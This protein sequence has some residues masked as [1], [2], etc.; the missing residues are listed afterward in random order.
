MRMK[1][2]IAAILFAG[3][4][5]AARA[6]DPGEALYNAKCSVCHQAGGIGAPGQYPP[7]KNRIDKIA[8]SAEGKHYLADLLLYGMV[9]KIQA[10]GA[11]YIGYMPSFKQ[12]PDADIATILSWLSSEGD[13]KPA[14][15]FTADDIAAARAKPISSPDVG[16]ERKSLAQIHPLP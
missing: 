9:G 14:P 12:L 10:G 13:T 16:K 15:V 2:A 1:C 7:L 3:S 4:V 8:S 5:Q 6:A 11:S